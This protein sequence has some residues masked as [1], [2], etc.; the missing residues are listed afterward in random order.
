MWYRLLLQF[1]IVMC[2]KAGVP[3]NLYCL[4]FPGMCKKRAWLLVC[5][6]YWRISLLYTSQVTIMDAWGKGPLGV[7]AWCS[8]MI[9]RYLTDNPF[10][11]RSNF[12]FFISTIVK[13]LS[14]FF[15]FSPRSHHSI[16]TVT[17][18][19]VVVCARGENKRNW[20]L[21][22]V[23]EPRII[24]MSYYRI[25]PFHHISTIIGV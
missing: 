15:F 11:G 6:A 22:L 19:L 4:V 5:S 24:P 3:S 7:F 18:M 8:H 13:P 25:V 12:S 1:H 20:L 23:V 21:G 10:N 16:T 9:W 14:F 2:G 17:T